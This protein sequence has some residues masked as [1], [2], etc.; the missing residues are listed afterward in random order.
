[1][2]ASGALIGRSSAGG[3]K[4]P[5]LLSRGSQAHFLH[6]TVLSLLH[7]LLSSSPSSSTASSAAC[8]L[9]TTTVHRPPPADPPALA[10]PDKTDKTSYPTPRCP[11][12]FACVKRRGRKEEYKSKG[13]ASIC[14]SNWNKSRS[15]RER[16]KGISACL[17]CGL[18]SAAGSIIFISTRFPRLSRAY[19]TDNG[20]RTT[21]NERIA[22]R[23]TDR[24]IDRQTGALLSR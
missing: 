6:P 8:V 15:I 4:A 23:R 20:Q 22:D 11:P 9:S 10:I 21:N 7:L 16:Q 19:T 5:G 12:A 14:R 3:Q 1:M 24:Q 2:P 18:F 17:G 13:K